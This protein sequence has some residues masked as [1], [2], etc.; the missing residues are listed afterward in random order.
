MLHRFFLDG[1]AEDLHRCRYSKGQQLSDDVVMKLTPQQHS[2]QMWNLHLG[3]NDRYLR[4]VAV[5][6]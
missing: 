4:A 3:R 6:F 1:L 2:E 5:Y